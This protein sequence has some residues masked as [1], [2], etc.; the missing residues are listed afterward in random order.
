MSWRCISTSVLLGALALTPA[1]AQNLERA[2]MPGPLSEAHARLEGECGNC[3]VRFNRA[4]Q[5]QRCLDCHKEVASDVRDRRGYHGRLA[6]RQCSSC[7]TEHKGRAT[8]IVR[9][10]EAR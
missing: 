8:R 9:L 10:D 4:E 3:H 2:I 1:Y 5:S 6:E 7:H